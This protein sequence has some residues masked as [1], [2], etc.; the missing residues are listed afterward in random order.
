[1]DEQN[2][3]G[4]AFVIPDLWKISSLAS[5]DQASTTDPTTLGLEP[6]GMLS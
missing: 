5:F 6:L 4:N 1:M 2:D 3:I